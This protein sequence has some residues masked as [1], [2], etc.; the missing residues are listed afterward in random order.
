VQDLSFRVATAL[1]GHFGVEWDVSNISPEERQGLI[2]AIRFYKEQR[3]LLHRGEVVHGD[4][5]DPAALVH[6]VVA[7]DKS[8]GLFAYVQL[9]TSAFSVPVSVRL[10]GLSPTRLYRVTPLSPVGV[11]YSVQLRPPPWYEGSVALPGVALDR[12]G[13]TLPVLGPEQAVLLKVDG[14]DPFT[15]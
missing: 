2:R 15:T 9:S 4:H 3:Q 10:P 8:E 11:P 1:F 7:E 6:G 13:L 5:P 14:I 12:I